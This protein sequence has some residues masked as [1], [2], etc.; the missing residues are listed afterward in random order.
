LDIKDKP[1]KIITVAR[2]PIRGSATQNVIEHG[3]GAL[4]IDGT[5]INQGEQPQTTTA[6]GW[7][8]INRKNAE[9]G[10]RPSDYDQGG[11]QYVP[12]NLGRW[13]ANVI[14]QGDAVAADLDEQGELMGAHSAGVARTK[15]V[16]SPYQASSYRLMVTRQ[17]NRFGDEG[18]VSRFFKQVKP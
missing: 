11:A 17:M 15:D 4:N 8:S 12:S 2:K 10:Y 1:M 9:H 13:P 6:P 18:G 5:R 14:L 16:T 3:C 7:D